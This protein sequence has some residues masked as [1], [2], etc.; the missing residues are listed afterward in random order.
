MLHTI[1]KVFW[2]LFT[3]QSVFSVPSAAQKVF[4]ILLPLKL[5]LTVQ[6]TFYRLATVKKF[7]YLLSVFYRS[8]YYSLLLLSRFFE[9]LLR[10]KLL[11]L[12]LRRHFRGCVLF[13]LKFHIKVASVWN[14]DTCWKF[15]SM[16]PPLLYVLPSCM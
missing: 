8:E 10:F 11:Y 5:L 16:L 14:W 13:H 15:H 7:I 4:K 3:A 9:F 2:V 12:P 1:W 6:K